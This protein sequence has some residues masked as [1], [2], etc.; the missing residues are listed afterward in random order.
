MTVD[1]CIAEPQAV[2]AEFVKVS[3]VKDKFPRYGVRVRA[4]L[5]VEEYSIMNVMRKRLRN[6]NESLV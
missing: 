4:S 6:K 2:V 3:P 1:L 5:E